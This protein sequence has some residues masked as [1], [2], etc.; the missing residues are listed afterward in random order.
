M[1]EF[2]QLAVFVVPKNYPTNIGTLFQTINRV[3]TVFSVRETTIFHP[4]EEHG[5]GNDLCDC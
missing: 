2:L 4:G 1:V 3:N 5:K